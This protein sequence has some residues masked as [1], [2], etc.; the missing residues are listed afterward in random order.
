MGLSRN[1]RFSALLGLL[2]KPKVKLLYV[3][4]GSYIFVL[5]SDRRTPKRLLEEN[6]NKRKKQKA[7]QSVRV[8]RD[9]TGIRKSN[10]GRMYRCRRKVLKVF[11]DVDELET[12]GA[13]G[14]SS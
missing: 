10:A 8:T 3:V 11:V 9:L 2:F 7:K 4:P 6:N 5:A 1:C 12:T 13:D 14:R